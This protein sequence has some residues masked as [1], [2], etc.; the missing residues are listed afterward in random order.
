MSTLAELEK[1]LFALLGT[2]LKVHGFNAKPV[3]Q[4]FRKPRSFGWAAIHLALI[5]HPP[6]DFDVVVNV[7]I[8]FDAIEELTGSTHPLIKSSDRKKAATIGCELGNLLGV[9]QK[10]WTIASE[11]DLEPVAA[12]IMECCESSIFPFI[13][14]YSDLGTVLETLNAGGE[15][16]SLISP[17]E[18][19]RNRTLEAL[20]RMQSQ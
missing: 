1:Q 14:K 17:L 3:D 8:R 9:G 15:T 2:L 16:A 18:G 11:G 13:E 20:L 10:R 12:Q 4:S 7:A 6:T 5:R 19:K